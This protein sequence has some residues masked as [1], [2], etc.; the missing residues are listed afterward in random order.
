MKICRKW[1]QLY[2]WRA[3]NGLL[4]S[5]KVG[6]YMVQIDEWAYPS[7]GASSPNRGQDMPSEGP[8]ALEISLH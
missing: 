8:P 3:M 1:Q 7:P 4:Q 5:D 6:I 2:N